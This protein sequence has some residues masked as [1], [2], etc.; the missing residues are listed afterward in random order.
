[1]Y[2]AFVA[3]KLRTGGMKATDHV[4]WA[5]VMNTH[6][7]TPLAA[8]DAVD[9]RYWALANFSLRLPASYAAE[10]SFQDGGSYGIFRSSDGTHWVMTSYPGVPICPSIVPAVV[11]HLWHLVS[12]GAC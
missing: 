4:T 12:Y 3:Y 11:A 2:H 7:T 1:M 5:V 9:H 6:S 10:V 8:Y